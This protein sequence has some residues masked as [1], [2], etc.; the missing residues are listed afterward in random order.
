MATITLA[1]DVRPDPSSWAEQVE[2]VEILWAWLREGWRY[3]IR[4]GNRRL[5]TN[6]ADYLEQMNREME[7]IISKDFVSYFLLVSDIVRWAKDNGIAVGPGR[8]SSAASLVCYLLRITEPDPLQFPLTDFTRFIDPTRVDL[9]DID[10]DFDDK[11]RYRVRQYAVKRWGEDCVANI[12]TFTKYKGKNSLTDVGRVFGV[13]MGPLEIVKGMIIERSGGDSRADA[14]L[15]DT[16]DTFP[17]AAEVLAKYPALE[18][19]ILLEGNYRGMSTHAAGLVISDT[20]IADVCAMYTRDIHG[21]SVAAVSVDKK[22]AEY[23]GLMKIDVLGLTTMGELAE[24]LRLT[25]M[26][27]EDLYALPLDDQ[28]TFDAFMAADVIGVFQFEGRATRLICREVRPENIFEL[29]HVNAL[30]RPGPLFSGTTTEFIQIKRGLMEIPLIHP[31][32]DKIAAPTRGQIIYQEQVLHAL[33]QFG[34]LPIGRVH[35]IRRI[36]SQKLGEAQFNASS[37]D[38]ITNAMALNGVSREV[39]AKVWERV[40][41]SASYAFVYSHSLAYSIIGYWCQWFKQHYPTQFF[42]VKLGRTP[43]KDLPILVK[44]S[45]RH[46]VHVKGVTLGASG[47][48]WTSPRDGELVA[49]FETLPGVGEIVAAKIMAR[50]E[51]RGHPY[52]HP[53]DLL[54]VSGIGPKTLEKML[55]LVNVDDPFGLRRLEE[56]MGR[57]RNWI[58]EMGNLPVPTHT[59]DELLDVSEENCTFLGFVLERNYQDFVENQRARYGYE[60]KDILARMRRPDLKTSVVLRCVDDGDEDVYVRVNRYDFPRLKGRIDGIHVGRDM[61][62]IRGRKSDKVAA[63]GISVQTKWLVSIDPND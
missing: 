45:E 8:G 49:G 16:F 35:D 36:I 59:S 24:M 10:V 7:L 39:A 32:L 9:P 60:V 50:Q 5:I 13:P 22:D 37:E 14:S 33:G 17:P 19:A 20:P 18:K 57:V 40:V 23:L 63:F 1:K 31:I 52:S 27:L 6:Q 34:G 2:P 21:R 29:I 12:G 44:D 4:Q 61:V 11:E 38:F 51:E 26:S 41:T 58:R 43:D 3:R 54:E 28:L 48:G 15:R 46:K 42:Q 25:G 56:D 47:T 30:S 55:P 62:L 53:S